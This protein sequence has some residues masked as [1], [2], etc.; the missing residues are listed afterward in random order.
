M[1]VKSSTS[2]KS[3]ESNGRTSYTLREE[4][5]NEGSKSVRVREVENG[6]V[7]SIEH[8]YYE[9]EGNNRQY[10]CDEKQYISKTNPLLEI[11]EDKPKV[12]P[13]D[14]KTVAKSISSFIS[15][16]SGKILM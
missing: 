4:Y 8:S 9:G 6:F 14:T 15:S 7:I 13:T 11:K 10:H 16:M 2:G 3:I 12:D 1:E 5:D